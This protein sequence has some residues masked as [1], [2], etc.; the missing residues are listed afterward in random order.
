MPRDRRRPLD[1]AIPEVGITPRTAALH[2]CGALTARQAQ[3]VIAPAL[4]GRA[5][6]ATEYTP[7]L[8][9]EVGRAAATGLPPPCGRDRCSC[10]LETPSLIPPA[11][12]QDGWGRITWDPPAAPVAHAGDVAPAHPVVHPLVGHALPRGV[13][14]EWDVDL[15]WW[16]VG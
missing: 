7:L 2:R 12:A 1:A 14:D 15:A 10:A 5:A 11:A 6:A 8:G 9:V 3:A 16:C 13:F 4:R